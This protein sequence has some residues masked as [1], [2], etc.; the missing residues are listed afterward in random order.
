MAQKFI[1]LVA[2]VKQ[3]IEAITASAG[4]GDTGKIPALDASGRLDQSFMPVGIGADLKNIV[5]SEVLAT[6]DLVNIWD[7]AGTPKARKAD[8]SAVGKEAVGFVKA[9][10]ALGAQASVY[11]EGTMTGL[12]GL[13]PGARYYVSPTAAGQATATAPTASG[14]VVQYVGR[15]I[16]TTEISFEHDDAIQIA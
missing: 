10:V 2:G 1:S 5:A 11:F 4:A 16:S 14:Q 12:T 15:A 13:T 6:N 3:L 8:A 7:D 9:G